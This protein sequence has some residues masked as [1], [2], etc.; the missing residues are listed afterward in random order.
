MVDLFDDVVYFVLFVEYMGVVIVSIIS[1]C[2]F[3]S[4]GLFFWFVFVFNMI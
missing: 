4:S 2:L 1:I 3:I